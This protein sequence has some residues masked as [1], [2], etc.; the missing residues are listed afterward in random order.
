M[1][2]TMGG[3]SGAHYIGNLVGL[4]RSPRELFRR[5]DQSASGGSV[6]LYAVLWQVASIVL[7]VVLSFVQPRLLPLGLGGKFVWLFVGPLVGL[8]GL[9]IIS[10]V[11][12]FLWHVMGS[13]HRYGVALRAVALLTPLEVLRT[14]L[15]V[16]P[17]LHVV[18]LVFAAYLLV[19]ISV[20]VHG[21]KPR[22]AWTVWFTLLGLFLL[23][24]FLA[25]LASRARST[26]WEKLGQTAP[27]ADGG[28][29][30]SGQGM[31]PSELQKKMED[32]LKK[33]QE[34]LKNIQKGGAGQ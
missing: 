29:R 32:E 22:L 3:F 18:V 8:A 28:P 25:T 21:I 33:H 16:M 11:L 15:G 27:A 34:N 23:L 12:F 5:L 26:P 7:T 9:F 24:G 17:F 6:L 19:V 14:I 1:I 30:L 31:M 2:D 10:A 20:E 4:F 13:T